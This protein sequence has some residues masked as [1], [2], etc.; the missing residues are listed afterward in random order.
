LRFGREAGAFPVAAPEFGISTHLFHDARLDREHLV[1]VAAHGFEAI[2]LFA[3]RSHFD[4]H[5]PQAVELLAEWLDDTR[6]SLH[7]VHAPI[8]ASLVN[9]VW[10]EAWSTAVADEKRRA[11][12]VAECRQA[13]E[14]AKVLHYDYLVVHLGV[15][16]D[17]KPGAGDNQRDAARRT[18]E[19]LHESAEAAGVRLALEVIPNALSRPEPLV[20][21][22]EDVLELPRVGICLDTGH[23]RLVGDVVDA[24]ETCSGHVLTTH[25]HDNHGR[26]DDHLVPFDGS[27]DWSAALLAFQKVGYDGRWMFELATSPQPATTLARAARA[28]QRFEETLGLADELMG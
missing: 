21:L 3:T 26:K 1:E 2:E 23:A 14:L 13:L 12:T 22:I 20:T 8:T 7:S 17:Q 25:L 16:D 9:G 11:H 18:I 27:I 28:R 6:L 5:D 19:E 15:P 4:Y 24:I 10:G